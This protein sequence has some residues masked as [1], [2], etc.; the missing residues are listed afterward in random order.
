MSTAHRRSRKVPATAADELSANG[1]GRWGL[2]LWN[3]CASFNEWF[4]QRLKWPAG[5]ERQRLDDLRTALPDG[6]FESLLLA[7]REHLERKTPLDLRLRA[8]LPD[9]RFESWHVQGTADHNASGHP[10]HLSG[11][12]RAEA[13]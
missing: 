6:A 1:E 4:Y 13:S 9:G 11:T 5:I 8:R 7:I 2:D 3:G 10:V 12:M